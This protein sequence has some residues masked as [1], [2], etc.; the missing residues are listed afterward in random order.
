MLR[1]L[2]QRDIVV[3]PKSVHKER[4][5]ENFNVFDFVLSNQDMVAIKTLD[6]NASGFLNHTDPEVV[7]WFSELK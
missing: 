1:W 2:I 6:T 4:I 3:I 7:K 5:A